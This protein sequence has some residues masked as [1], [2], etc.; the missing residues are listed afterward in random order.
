MKH[1]RKEMTVTGK[2]TKLK[3]CLYASAAIAVILS[4]TVTQTTTQVL[5]APINGTH[6]SVGLDPDT[7]RTDFEAAATHP[8]AN[9]SKTSIKI[10]TPDEVVNDAVHRNTAIANNTYKDVY[11][12]AEFIEAWKDGS[13]T[14]IEVMTDLPNASFSNGERPNGASVIV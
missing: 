10:N 11:S 7:K 1:K 13:R 8:D 2:Q 5:A 3:R 12:I 14:Y 4:G 9:K 6:N